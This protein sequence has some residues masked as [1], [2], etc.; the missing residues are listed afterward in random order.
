MKALRRAR[1]GGAYAVCTLL[2]LAVSAEKLPQARSLA[3]TAAPWNSQAIQST[4]AGV[5]IRELN[6]AKSEVVLLYDLDNKTDQ[7]YQLA[8]GPGVLIMTRLK[9]TGSLSS[10][11]QVVLA[12]PAFVPA[13]NRTRIELSITRA[14]NWPGRMDA[15]AQMRIRQLVSGELPDLKGF[16]L[17]DQDSRYQIELPGTWPLAEKEP[18]QH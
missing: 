1:V 7:D 12:A 10:E 8:K 6:P 16:V 18:D 11:K 13:R 3:N 17:F 9:S 14:F 15:A 5:R 2:V 4:F